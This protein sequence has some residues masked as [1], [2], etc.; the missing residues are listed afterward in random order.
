MNETVK[1]LVQEVLTQCADTVN[2]EMS[3]CDSPLD[4]VE[5]VDNI[6]DYYE[7]SNAEEFYKYD[8]FVRC[9]LI[10]ALMKMLNK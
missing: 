10:S 6:L 8:D 7:P 3:L 9:Q 1:N 4:L 2:Y 5:A